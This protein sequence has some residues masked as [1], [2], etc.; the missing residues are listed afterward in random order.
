MNSTR[1]PLILAAILILAMATTA[2]AQPTNVTIV[3]D[4]QDELGC[5]GDWQPD[6]ASTYLT[7]DAGDDVW[8]ATF[9]LPA[10]AFQYKATLN[11]AWDEN[12]G[13]NAQAGGANIPL[14]LGDA[15]AVKFYYDD[16]THWITDNVNSVIATAVGDFQS[17]IGCAGDWDPSCLHSWMQDPDGDGVYTYSTDAIPP[18]GYEAKVVINEA[19]DES[20]PG[21]NVSFTV[22][23]SSAFVTFSY[24]SATNIVAIDVQ[25][26][27]PP[28]VASV[29]IVGSLQSELGC[30]GDWQPDCASTH[31]TFDTDDDVWQGTFSVP[32]GAWEYKAA[33]NDNW[34]ENYGANAQMDGANISLTL[35]TETPVKFYYDHKSHWATD[36]V[37]SVIATAVGDF[38]SEVGCAGDW[39]PSCLRSWLQD[40]DGDGIYTFFTT[41]IPAGMYEAKA[42]INESWDESYGVDGVP[43]GA[44]IPFVV[45]V[46]GMDVLFSYDAVTHI[47]SITAEGTVAVESRSWGGVKALYR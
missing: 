20:Y 4:F 16:K 22:T 1:T 40:P 18:G 42:A 39:D 29:T 34:T 43:G 5:P 32:A 35:G 30:P 24:D 23:S 26:D 47:L 3:G 46:S 41:D 11:N 33:L 27:P 38:Q 28:E 37:N 8:Q 13:A 17:E 45:P 15:T 14:N 12:Y 2:T 19:W 9:S 36:N 10:G 44:N 6:C 7:Y 31:L 21:G 25:G